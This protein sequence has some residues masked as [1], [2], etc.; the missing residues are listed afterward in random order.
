MPA[1]LT[2]AGLLG[3][4]V[5]LLI[6]LHSVH[7]ETEH[8]PT[9]AT[10]EQATSE[11]LSQPDLPSGSQLSPTQQPKQAVRGI[12]DLVNSLSGKFLSSPHAIP[13]G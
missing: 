1:A 2:S 4:F 13:P 10:A 9:T 8:P 5:A 3:T 12:D 11:S 7:V 6:G